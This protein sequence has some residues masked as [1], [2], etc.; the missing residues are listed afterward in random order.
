[1]RKRNH[2]LVV[3]LGDNELDDLRKRIN[4]SGLSFQAYARKSMLDKKIAERPC[5]H[6]AELLSTLSD[7]SNGVGVILRRVG[8]DSPLTERD[9]AELRKLITD[10]WHIV[11]ERY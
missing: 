9:I 8:S 2:V 5:E 3:Y 11:S 10:T 6:H 4:Q 1:M 7:I